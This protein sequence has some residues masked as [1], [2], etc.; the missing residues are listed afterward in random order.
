MLDGSLVDRSLGHINYLV[1]FGIHLGF[2][3]FLAL[4]GLQ[5]SNF[6][7]LDSV[8]DGHTLDHLNDCHREDIHTKYE[9]EDEIVVE[10]GKGKRKNRKRNS[11]RKERRSKK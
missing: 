6:E 8:A 7:F 5:P 3:V 9:V 11:I 10:N 2:V 4:C 1:F